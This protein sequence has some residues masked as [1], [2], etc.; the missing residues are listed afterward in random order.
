MDMSRRAFISISLRSQLCQRGATCHKVIDKPGHR[1]TD[2]G[3]PIALND[4]QVR[5]LLLH[6][7]LLVLRRVEQAQTHKEQGRRQHQADTKADAP[8][9]ITGLVAVSR[10]DN[11]N[12]DACKDK[13]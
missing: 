10:K 2:H 8:Q 13:S 11:Q 9:A 4:Q 3:L 5:G 1:G 6:G 12:D 7:V